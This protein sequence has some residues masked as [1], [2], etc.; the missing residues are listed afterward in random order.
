METSFETAY[1]LDK[2]Y[3]MQTY[4]RKLIEF[5]RGSGMRLYDSNGAEY[6]DFLSGIGAVSMGHCHPA[7][8][9]ALV[10]Q[11][12]KLLHVSNYFYVENRGELAREI[13][14]LLERN[15]A[16]A[17]GN[18]GSTWRTFF[19]NSG[20]EANEGAI[21]LARRWG[22]EHKGGATSIVTAKR[23]FHGRTLAALFA[24]GQENKQE[25]FLPPVSGFAHVPLNDIDALEEELRNPTEGDVVALMLEC[26][27]GEG[28]VWPCTEEYMQ[29]AR[30]LTL[31]MGMLLIIDE[32]Q[33]GFYRTGKPFA[34]QHFGIVPDVVS[35]A[36][37]MGN[38]APIAGVCATDEIAMAFRPGDHGSTFGGGPLVCAASLATLRAFR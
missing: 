30:A 22:N 34:F 26:V 20:A 11:A 33:T 10:E 18:T 15:D 16:D 3:V 14:Y 25:A 8:T 38:G 37:G 4:G 7:V 32:V 6:L 31:E 24:T 1:E 2:T 17:L 29:A 9:A 28:G 5:V 19:A 35:I 12:Q 21:K 36:K 23:S 27:Q 13:S